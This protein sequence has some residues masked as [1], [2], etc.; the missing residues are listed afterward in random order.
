MSFESFSSEILLRIFPDPIIWALI[1]CVGFL[2]LL[3]ITRAPMSVG[4]QLSVITIYVISAYIHGIFDIILLLA[5]AA[6]GIVLVFGI[7]RL[8]RQY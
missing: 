1:F 4:L 3:T 8:G 2:V 5:L 7:Q 6:I